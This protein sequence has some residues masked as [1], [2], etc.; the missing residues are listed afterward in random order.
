MASTKG[1]TPA[2][3]K[4]ATPVRNQGAKAQGDL[5]RITVSIPE[6]GKPLLE[7]AAKMMREGMDPRAAL[8]KA[9]GAQEGTAAPPSRDQAIRSDG[10]AVLRDQQQMATLRVRLEKAE[11]DGAAE[12]GRQVRSLG[13]WRLFLARMAGLRH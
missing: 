2:K 11:L 5:R 7:A 1:R 8:L 6:A 10:L 12:I 13:G 3:T 4:Q 9:G